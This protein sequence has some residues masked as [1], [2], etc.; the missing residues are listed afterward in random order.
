M[1]GKNMNNEYELVGD[2]FIESILYKI[3]KKISV[4]S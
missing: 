4:N 2:K 3:Y 1:K